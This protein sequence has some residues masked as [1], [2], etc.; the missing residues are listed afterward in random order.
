MNGVGKTENI[1]LCF[2]NL[3]HRH[4]YPPY[5]TTLLQTV[6]EQKTVIT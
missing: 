3:F 5:K 6:N 4:A 2:N 1:L